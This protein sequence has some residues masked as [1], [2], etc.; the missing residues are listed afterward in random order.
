VTAENQIV[1]RFKIQ[2]V[3]ASYAA[4]VDERDFD[5]Y[6]S[7]FAD[8]VEVL[9]FGDATING[10][11]AWLE[12]VRKALER[13]GPTQ[14]MLGPPWVRIEGDTAHAR[15][16]VQ[17]L[18]YMKPEE[19]KILTLWATYETDFARV[20]DGWKIKRHRLVSRGTQIS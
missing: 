20:G 11:D 8:D 10:A 6:R 16:D 19:E 2:D 4:G 12:Y 13:F 9:D 18:H 5:L 15:T 14:H 7:C 3:M 1:D 17:A